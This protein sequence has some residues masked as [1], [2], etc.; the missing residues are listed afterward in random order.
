MG[1]SSSFARASAS[2]PH[3]NQSTGLLACCFRYRLVSAARRFGVATGTPGARRGGTRIV[4][5]ETRRRG[6][7]ESGEEE[8][9]PGLGF[10]SPSPLL[11]V[12]SSPLLPLCHFA[13]ASTGS[14]TVAPPSR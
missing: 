6:D 10:L 5:K 3:G 11:R 13:S 12:S 14:S 9:R 7:R 1:R 8:R 4:D 2:G